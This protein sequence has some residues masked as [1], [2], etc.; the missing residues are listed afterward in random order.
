MYNIGDENKTFKKQYFPNFGFIT[1]LVNSKWMN[2]TRWMILN[3][4]KLKRL[5]VT[6]TCKSNDEKLLE[7]DDAG[8][9]GQSVEYGIMSQAAVGEAQQ[10]LGSWILSGVKLLLCTDVIRGLSKYF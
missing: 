10:S 7:S 2:T 4:T 6:L 8:P 3:S 9:A 5:N 1:L